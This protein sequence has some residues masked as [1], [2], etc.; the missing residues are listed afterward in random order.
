MKKP[1]RLTGTLAL[2]L[3]LAWRLDWGRVCSAFAAL[4]LRLW[5]TALGVY[6][7]AQAASSLRW[8]MLARVLG[9]AGGFGRFTAYYFIGMFFNLVLPTSVGGDVV[10]AWYVAR[11]AGPAPAAGRRTAAALSVF[12]DRANGLA[13]LIAL[14]CAAVAVY[15]GHM[16]P[17]VSLVVAGMGTALVAGLAVLPLLLRLRGRLA[18]RPRLAQ[19][20]QGASLCLGHRWLMVGVTLLSLLVQLA[21]VLQTWLV[22]RGLGLP[23]SLS[24][25][26]ILTSVVSVLTL[27]P[28]SVNGMGLRETG[29][30]VLLAPLG[31]DTA[32][33]VTLGLLTFAVQVAA[34]LGGGFCYVLGRFPRFNADADRT[35]AAAVEVRPDAPALGGDPDQ[36]RARQSRTAA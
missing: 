13:V 19:V 29:T 16:E 22:A 5:L 2:A 25:S 30:A 33:A 1:W 28:I 8:L 9:I 18:V 21:S 6:L 31:I 34:S 10:R 12:I 7:V 23:L 11:Q 15:R 20:L 17:W 3:L 24:Y 4:D 14:S 36:G 35:G 32:N 27:L 26:C